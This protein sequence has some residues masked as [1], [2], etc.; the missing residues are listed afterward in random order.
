L[1]RANNFTYAEDA[2]GLQCPFHAHI[3]IV[4][5]RGDTVAGRNTRAE[6]EREH[7]IVRRGMTYGRR[8]P[9]LLDAPEYGVGL[10]FMC[11]QRSIAHQF[12]WMQQRGAGNPSLANPGTGRDPLIG[13][14]APGETAAVP[15]WPAEWGKPETRPFNFE[16]Y[17]ALKG[18]EFFFAPSLRFLTTCR[19]GRST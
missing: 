5:P 11:F 6:A 15:Q 4:N 1:A 12:A 3:R 7:R 9:D 14:R 19:S 2:Q 10:L 13:Q 16:S 17:I 18:G 8:R